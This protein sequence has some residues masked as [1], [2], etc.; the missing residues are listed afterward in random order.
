[1]P[2]LHAFYVNQST[3]FIVFLILLSMSLQLQLMQWWF[4]PFDTEKHYSSE[5]KA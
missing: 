3:I 1:M 5:Q 2:I 4:Q